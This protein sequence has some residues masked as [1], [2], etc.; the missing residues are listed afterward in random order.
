MTANT[1]ERRLSDEEIKSRLRGLL[2]DEQRQTLSEL[3]RFGWELKFVRRPMFQPSIPVIVDG[4]RR[5]YAVLELDGT[6]NENP[7][8]DIRET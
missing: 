8:F 4:D 3:E 6:L 5:T 2:N 1:I 7:G